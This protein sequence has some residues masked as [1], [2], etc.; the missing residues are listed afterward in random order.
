MS[1]YFAAF[2]FKLKKPHIDKCCVKVAL[3][4]HQ[5]FQVLDQPKN[6]QGGGG[7][8]FRAQENLQGSGTFGQSIKMYICCVR[9]EGGKCF[10]MSL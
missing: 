6:S 3:L 8:G 5:N 4:R 2:N 7:K 1:L 9:K 10:L